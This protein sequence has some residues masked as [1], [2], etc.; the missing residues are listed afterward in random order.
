MLNDLLAVERGLAARGID[1]V[2]RH[3]DVKDMAKGPALRVR[4]A[5]DGRL[6]SVEI[7]DEAGRGA[8][9]TLRDGQHNGF[10]GLK[11]VR[12]LLAL[13][14]PARNAHQQAWDADKTPTHRRG[15]LL[16]LLGAHKVDAG[17]IA[18]WPNAGHRRRIK[19]RLETLRPLSGDAL[20]ASVPAVFERFL[21]ALS[22]RPSL[23]ELLT[24]ALAERVRDREDQWL[25]FVRAALIGPV[26]LAID[27]AEGDF[28]RDAADPRQIPAVSQALSEGA[29]DDTSSYAV[30]ALSGKPA[31]LHIGN[32]PQPNLPGLG[33][34][35][36]FSRNRDIPSLT[37][38][39]RTADASL[40]VDSALLR[41]L[42]G[43][44]TELT[45][46]HAKGH[47]WCL[48]PAETGDQPDLLV[49]S[50]SGPGLRLADALADD[51]AVGGEAA[52]RE[53][54]SRLIEQSGGIY[55]HDHPQDELIVLVLRTV[56]PANR[57]AIYHRRTT[58]TEIWEAA[59][60]W[61]AA[62]SNT[63][64]WLGF[65]LPVKDKSEP[66]FRRPP[67]VV[68]QSITPLSRTQFANG[69]RRRVSVIGVTTA[70]AFSLFLHEGNVRRRAS[71]LLNLLLERHG[72][73]LGGLAAARRKGSERLKDF[74]PKTDLRR[75]ALRS[76]TWLGALLHHLGRSK[77]VYMSDAGFRLGQLLAAA[78][79]VHVG[80][81]LD[82]RKGSVPPSLLGNA[83]LGIAAANPYGALELLLRRW[84]P[85]SSWAKNS[86]KVLADAAQAEIGGAKN[87][88][89]VLR[90][91]LSQAH[92]I[93]PIAA[94]LREQLRALGGKTDHTFR[95][96][97]LL[98]YMAGLPGSKK[99]DRDRATEKDGQKLGENE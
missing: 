55:R 22:R 70:A 63:P 95:A 52:L 13:D 9:W 1:L 18:I 83:V 64:E 15:E 82:V 35:Y 27:V 85:Y 31:K 10:P 42:S 40:A 41:R 39:G 46:D 3:P 72:P 79:V 4:L 14:E 16:R 96:E 92:R 69:G 93:S 94:E 76:V 75:D 47:T 12:G 68:P 45:R 81:C 26:A 84:P 88:A 54:G 6:V 33:Q 90:T 77:E 8:L 50:M 24:D 53:L 34:T 5:A 74:D 38:Y 60:R 17:Q 23:L 57:K 44:V 7:V 91:A 80:Y 98:G 30:C 66:L 97:L 67:Y 29:Q 73:L 62:T 32:F 11:T 65:P 71:E 86:A 37:R 56:D 59:R 19:E 48:M 36:I 99:N 89:I 87:K 51:D 25:D 2:D 21:A 20:T 78:D 61:Q 43:A 58:A 49:V 28:E